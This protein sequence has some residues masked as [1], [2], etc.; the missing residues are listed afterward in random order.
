MDEKLLLIKATAEPVGLEIKVLDP[1]QFKLL[2]ARL[3]KARKALRLE[4]S[5]SLHPS[6][7]SPLDT[8]W[9]VHRAQETGPETGEGDT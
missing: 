3:Y 8:I 7:K 1:K 2:Q 5:I 6:R 4:A 9:I